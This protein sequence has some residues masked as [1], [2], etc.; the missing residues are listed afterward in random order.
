M[1]AQK[2]MSIDAIVGPSTPPPE[3]LSP[4][5]STFDSFSSSGSISPTYSEVKYPIST[6][7]SPSSV[8]SKHNST[9]LDERRHRNKIAS[10]KY[11]AKKQASM[12]AMAQKLAELSAE[13][14]SLQRELSR[15]NDDN[16]A[17]RQVCESLVAKTQ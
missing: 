13:N 15:A 10:A 17:L 2:C 11:R 3:P 9:S 7:S 4:P 1:S 8:T 14:A 12:R 16:K 6:S 5:D